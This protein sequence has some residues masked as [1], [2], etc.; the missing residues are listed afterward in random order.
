MVYQ[1]RKIKVSLITVSSFLLIIKLFT[2]VIILK[3]DPTKFFVFSMS[4]SLKNQIKV[5]R[6]EN[7]N[8][9]VLFSDENEFVGEGLYF[10]V[11]QYLWWL[12]LVGSSTYFLLIR[13]NRHD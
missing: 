9:L 12:V 10:F 5:S 6:I 13:K 7:I 2:A 1:S 3:D 11:T 8:H 4:P